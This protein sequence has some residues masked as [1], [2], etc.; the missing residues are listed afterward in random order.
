VQWM[1]KTQSNTSAVG[2]VIE[3]ILVQEEGP[4]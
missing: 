1:S 3:G 4:L 2:M